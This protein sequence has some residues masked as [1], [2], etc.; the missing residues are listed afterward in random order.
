M[1]VVVAL[2]RA[3]HGR[4]VSLIDD[5]DVVEQFATDSADEALGDC[6]RSRCPN[7]GSSRLAKLGF[8]SRTLLAVWIERHDRGTRG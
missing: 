4:G 2:D 6:V 5:Q 8:T 1:I 7:R 3:E